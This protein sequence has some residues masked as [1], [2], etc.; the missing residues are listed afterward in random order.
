ML[1]FGSYLDRIARYCSG[2]EVFELD[3]NECKLLKWNRTHISDEY[4]T[5]GVHVGSCTDAVRAS[6]VRIKTKIQFNG[7]FND[8]FSVECFS[9]LLLRFQLVSI[10]LC[11]NFG[12]THTHTLTHTIRAPGS[13]T[14]DL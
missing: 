9:S 11:V 5:H 1:S 3:E 10:S 6:R 7:H 14:C 13:V 4:R 2:N 8:G 12:T